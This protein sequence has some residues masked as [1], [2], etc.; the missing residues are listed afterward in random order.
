MATTK[1]SRAKGFVTGF[2]HWLED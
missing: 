1:Y 2:R